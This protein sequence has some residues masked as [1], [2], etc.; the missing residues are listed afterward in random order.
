V[1][2]PSRERSEMAHHVF[3]INKE[4]R[5]RS[6]S[7]RDCCECC[8]CQVGVDVVY[9]VFGGKRREKEGVV[10]KSLRFLKGRDL[11]ERVEE[12]VCECASEQGEE[13]RLLCRRCG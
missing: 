1:V 10:A 6:L 9:Q 12:F 2:G 13:E 4:Y 7:Q 3:C 11:G 8:S 5:T